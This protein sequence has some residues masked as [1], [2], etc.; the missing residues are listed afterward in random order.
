MSGNGGDLLRRFHAVISIN[1]ERMSTSKYFDKICI[2]VTA[3]AVLLTVIFM[4]GKR[5]GIE[6]I[7]GANGY[8]DHLFDTSYVHEIDVV[9]KNFDDMCVKADKTWYDCDAVIDGEKFSNI[10][11]RIKGNAGEVQSLGSSK[12]S[13]RIGFDH[14]NSMESYHGLNK[15]DLNNS[16]GDCTFMK[17]FL[18]YE[19][20][21]GAGVP[22]PLCS[23]AFLTVNG[24]DVGLYLAVETVDDSFLMRNFGKNYGNLYK[25]ECE[26]TAYE[27]TI[28]SV[29]RDP[30]VNSDDPDIV[31]RTDENS[32]RDVS[33]DD[34]M[35]HI[36]P[37]VLSG[38]DQNRIAS[39]GDYGTGEST[40]GDYG[41]D[42]SA[43]A[44]YGTGDTP[45]S[46]DKASDEASSGISGE[47]SS[48]EIRD[49]MAIVRPDDI[50]LIYID[51]NSASYPNI[52]NSARQN[53]SEKDRSR[54]IR[55]L[56]NLTNG[57][58]VG[59]AVDTDEV[60]AY[61]AVHNF[62]VSWNSYTGETAGN[63]YLY[64]KRGRLS[65]LPWDYSSAFGTY[66]SED[67]GRMI[68]YP[69]DTPLLKGLSGRRPM[70]DWIM[71]DQRYVTAYHSAMRE[72]IDRYSGENDIS[73][74]LKQVEAM[75]IPYIERDQN[76]F[77]SEAAFSKGVDTLI[78]FW[79]LRSESVL[80][81]LNG[82]IPSTH[83]G[84]AESPDLLVDAS[85]LELI[86]ME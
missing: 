3:L 82:D 63:Y 69:V 10:S 70:F 28:Q 25:P 26:E 16:A 17:D 35:E 11:I 37:S 67:A 57:T 4:N 65:M 34:P 86:D 48:S 52:F 5:L 77:A 7:S 33:F 72:L 49:T 64:E 19:A 30:Q 31:G 15:L 2:I 36:D 22:S 44:D 23:Y 9:M 62:V 71:K 56:K 32:G 66:R 60:I 75:L 68:N 21:T 59:A 78:S 40:A 12:Y 20:M 38:D 54:L 61:F 50:K 43:S 80:G 79:M 58:D 73:H 42:K 76:K 8:E 74:R 13:F 83:E 46:M 47:S 39:A 41:T 14:R 81:Q 1:E 53:V 24:K 84:Q 27:K 45:D 85:G 18:V 29:G 51:D 55:A 6:S